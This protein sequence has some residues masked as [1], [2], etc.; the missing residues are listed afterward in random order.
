MKLYHLHPCVLVPLE[1]SN[2]MGLVRH[3]E[4]EEEQNL[5]LLEENDELYFI[6]TK[7]IGPRQEL[8]VW[9]SAE[10][11]KARNLPLLKSSQGKSNE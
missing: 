8:K 6:T 7:K 11:A 2:W 10:Y 5:A 3:A 4:N 1:E 9:Y